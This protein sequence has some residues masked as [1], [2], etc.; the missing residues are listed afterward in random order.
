MN[1]KI[2]A[3]AVAIAVSGGMTM[4]SSAYAGQSA[5]DGLYGKIRLGVRTGDGTAAG[6]ELDVISGKLVFGFKGSTDLDGG[7]TFSY[8][9]EFESDTADSE[10]TN[11]S[12]DVSWVALSGDFGKVIAGEH[13]DFAGFA[14]SGTDI[15]TNGTDE[16]CS[17]VHDTR[18]ANAVQ[19]RY[20][21][22][23]I[24]LGAA[25][26]MDGTGEN[27][28]H[29]GIQYAG[30]NFSVGAQ[31]VSAGDTT[32]Y[33]GGVG[34]GIPA[35]ESGSQIGG[36][37]TFGDITLGVTIA[38]TGADTDEDAIS[39]AV[40]LPLVGGNLA[41]L[42]TT[43]DALDSTVPGAGVKGDSIDVELS[44]SLAGG[45]FWGLEFNDDDLNAESIFYAYAGINF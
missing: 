7:N 17:L 36:H 27:P 2:L 25:Y 5:V 18:I 11:L 3:T 33:G 24:N 40:Q 22:G 37:Y 34:P 1:K 28:T 16:A 9:I 30:D 43:G 10:A 44:F 21:A 45:A 14:C 13:G 6:D 4:S 26:V 8:G 38:D 31:F 19:Y 42:S 12:N 35:G 15:L 23:A 32:S 29:L 41:I 20:N 39:V